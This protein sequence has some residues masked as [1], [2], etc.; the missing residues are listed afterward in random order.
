ML[1]GTGERYVPWLEDPDVSYE[2]LHRYAYAMQFVQNKR[3]LDLACGEG[4]GSRLLAR[5]AESVV[6]VDIDEQA[7]RHAGN[8]YIKNNLRFKKG[9][10]TNIPIEGRSI[11]D[12]IICF[13]AL[14]HI[15]DHEKLVKEVKRLLTG[16]GIFIVSTSNKWAYSDEP[17]HKNPFPVHGLYLDE[18]TELFE[19]YFKQ[20]KILGQRI[21]CN[22]NIWSIFPS[23]DSALSEYVIERTPR[24]F[25]FVESDKRTP[26]YFIAL[27]SDA[28]KNL[29]ASASNLVDISNELLN[30]KDRAFAVARERLQSTIKSQQHALSEKDQML[31]DLGAER[32][33]V[34]QETARLRDTILAQQRRLA[35]KEQ[36][37][38]Q[39]AAEREQSARLVQE[40]LEQFAAEREQSARLAQRQLEQF[41]AEREQSAQ[42]IVE[43]QEELT[44]QREIL[45]RREEE[46]NSAVLKREHLGRQLAQL[47]VTLE[48]KLQE[49]TEQETALLRIYQSHGWKALALYYRVRNGVFPE[50]TRRRVFAKQIFHAAVNMSKGRSVRKSIS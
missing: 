42:K 23:G 31:A 29:R 4:Y 6:G 22:S 8:K 44:S 36:Q 37:F 27:A 39:F 19:K 33:R 43:L 11:F 26:L 12:V 9:S 21:Y 49:L 40:Q 16:D 24:E 5:T 28:D 17:K 2:H 46:L 25:A 35:E 50:G 15:D 1:E 45:A 48:Q 30:Q 10:I 41:A 14:E 18:F 3:V 34:K 47:R 38:K 32:D 7:V 13:E 20:V